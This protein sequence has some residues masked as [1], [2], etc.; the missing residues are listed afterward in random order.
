LYEAVRSR[1]LALLLVAAAVLAGCSS[2]GG[3]KVTTATTLAS[4]GSGTGKKSG[5]SGGAGGSSGIAA[6]TASF[7]LAVG[8]PARYMVG[9]L[10]NDQR[11]VS[12]GTIQ[13]R[14]CFLGAQKADTACQ[15]G[16]EQ[17]ASFLAVPGSPPAPAGATPKVISSTESKGVYATQ[18][19]FDKAGIWR[20]EVSLSLDGKARQATTDFQV[21]D[22]HLVPAVGDAAL[23]TDNLTVSTPDTPPAAVDSRASAGG[24]IPDP[25]L[26]QTT[27]AAALAAHRPMV[28]VFAT[29]VYC[30][31]RFC[32]PTTDMVQQLAKTYGDRATFIHV[33]IWH[34]FQKQQL[35]KGA[36][37]WLYRN[38]DLNEP[39]V[40]FIGADGKIGARWDNVADQSEIESMLKPLPVIG[41]G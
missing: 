32:G 34:D 4:N 16:P 12:F 23:A 10:T 19:A 11:G 6:Q 15:Y 17:A 33:E 26:H 1:L 28:A 22:H 35:N 40:F 3:K 38:N 36:A 8:P 25:E 5:G 20:A 2:G 24:L 7:D 27:I 14:L 18:A 9:V 31:S 29:P 37:D 30:V 13:V 39:W 41:K 21:L